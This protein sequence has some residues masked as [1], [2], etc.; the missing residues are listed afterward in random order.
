MT[1]ALALAYAGARAFALSALS[2]RTA[3]R[4]QAELATREATAVASKQEY[5]KRVAMDLFRFMARRSVIA[6]FRRRLLRRYALDGCAARG[7][8][9]PL[10]VAATLR[11]RALS[12]RAWR[13][14]C[15]R[16]ADA[17]PRFP[18]QESFPTTP[19]GDTLL[20]PSNVLELWFRKFENRFARDPDFL[21]RA[22][23]GPL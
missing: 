3:P 12:G 16:V 21:L 20:V 14:R 19:R 6:C 8:A 1:R 23:P 11:W 10:R 4:A 18:P 15:S 17:T 2:T 13:A 22:P 9:T 5:A 7:A